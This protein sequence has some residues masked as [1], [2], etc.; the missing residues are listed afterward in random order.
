[1]KKIPSFQIDQT[2]SILVHRL[3][4]HQ[5]QQNPNKC[6]EECKKKCVQ[7]AYSLDGGTSQTS[8]AHCTNSGSSTSQPINSNL[9]FTSDCTTNKETTPT[10]F[11][12]NL[13]SV[14]NNN[15]M[16]VAGQSASLSMLSTCNSNKRQQQYSGKCNSQPNS[17]NASFATDDQADFQSRSH[18]LSQDLSDI[19]LCEQNSR[20]SFSL[21]KIDSFPA[22]GNSFCNNCQQIQDRPHLLQNLNNDISGPANVAPHINANKQFGIMSNE[23]TETVAQIEPCTDS[24]MTTPDVQKLSSAENLSLEDFNLDLM[25]GDKESPTDSHRKEGLSNITDCFDGYH[26]NLSPIHGSDILVN[27]DQLES[28][29][30]PDIEKICNDISN[31][32][33]SPTSQENHVHIVHKGNICTDLNQVT[34]QNGCVSERNLANGNNNIE[35]TGT[36]KSDFE[37]VTTR[38]CLMMSEVTPICHSRAG[39]AQH[40]VESPSTIAVITDFC[41]DWAYSEVGHSLV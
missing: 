38:E 11:I 36:G 24:Q 18:S 19:Q 28:L 12:L 32:S 5:E 27:L 13:G 39:N 33:N 34:I 3:I 25:S 4:D 6:L 21:S 29:D 10:P 14:V 8:S 2:I 15:L 35:C 17:R 30:L 31:E 7:R 16:L 9:L 23:K 20:S 1:M 40:P 26:T 37:T 22:A 41:P